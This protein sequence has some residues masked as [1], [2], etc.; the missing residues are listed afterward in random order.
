L[1]AESS[2][3]EGVVAFSEADAA[4]IGEEGAMAEGRGLPGEGLVEEELAGGG[5]KQIGAADDFGHAHEGVVDHAGQVVGG[6]AVMTP[7]DEVPEIDSGDEALGAAGDVMELDGRTI[8]NAEPPIDSGA[9]GFGA[10]WGA[11]DAGVDGVI[12]AGVGSGEGAE[13]IV[14]GARAGVDGFLLLEAVESGLVLGEAFALAVGGEGAAAVGAFVPLETEPGEILEHGGDEVRSGP[15]GVEVVVA[16]DEGTVVLLGAGLR[17]PEGP[18]VAEVEVA[19]GRWGEASPVGS[20]VA[21]VSVGR[22]G[23]KLRRRDGRACGA[24]GLARPWPVRRK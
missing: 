15:A 4:L 11:A 21:W 5:T 19:G 23:S 18:G 24:S 3:A 13:D 2:Q 9:G 22:H 1:G 17:G 10:V 14:S 8:R 16:E 20:R 12:I 7:N 6:E